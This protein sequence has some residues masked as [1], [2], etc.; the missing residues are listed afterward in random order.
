AW[1]GS[2]RWAW[3]EAAIQGDLAWPKAE[4]VQLGRRLGQQTVLGRAARWRR[5]RQQVP[6]GAATGVGGDLGELDHIAE[7]VGLAELALAD[8]AGVWVAHRHQPVGDLL[9]TGSLLDLG[10][11]A[12]VAVG[13][14]LQP[15]GSAELGPGAPATRR[16]ARLGGQ[17]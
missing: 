14:L 13:Q 9:A 11:D 6:A 1:P 3:H 8:R 2:G 17:R 10:G 4:A 12:L 16:G 5:R 15:L 7:L